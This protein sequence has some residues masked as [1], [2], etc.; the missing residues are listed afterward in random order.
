[1]SKLEEFISS[2]LVG[3]SSAGNEKWNDPYKSY[4]PSLLVS[5]KGTNAWVQSI[6]HSLPISHQQVYKPSLVVSFQGTKAWV[7][8]ILTF[9]TDFPPASF[10]AELPARSWSKT[11]RV[12]VWSSSSRGARRRPYRDIWSWV[13]SQIEPQ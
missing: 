6:P 10:S 13:Q 12:R 9:P 3:A 8:S 2:F 11:S 4:K 7:H 1:M 5:L